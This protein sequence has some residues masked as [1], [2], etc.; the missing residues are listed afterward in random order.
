MIESI[1]AAVSQRY[2]NVRQLSNFKT[3]SNLSVYKLEFLM[4]FSDS[5]L[6][7]ETG[8]LLEYL[9]LTK[10]PKYKDDWGC[11]FGNNI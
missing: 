7:A 2:I 6:N 8:E 1:P 5:S 9:H 4:D 11:S 10:R 3:S